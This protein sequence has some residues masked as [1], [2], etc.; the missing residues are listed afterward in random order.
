MSFTNTKTKPVSKT[1]Q[2]KQKAQ[3]QQN[4]NLIPPSAT[5][6]PSKNQGSLTKFQDKSKVETT[7]E[8]KAIKVKQ[9]EVLTTDKPLTNMPMTAKN[10][11]RIT[12]VISKLFAV[13]GQNIKVSSSKQA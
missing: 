13:N 1:T 2:A 9:E 6:I 10:N 12:K 5:L 7:K 4:L 8:L 3:K 11:E